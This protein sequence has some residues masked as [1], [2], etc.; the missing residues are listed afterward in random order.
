[1]KNFSLILFSFVLCLSAM[2]I[3]Q[4]EAV[5][6]KAKA[7]LAYEQGELDQAIIL[8]DSLTKEFRSL[9]LEYNL[10]NAYFRSKKIPL[11]ILHYERALRIAPTDV[12]VLHNLA[13]ARNLTVDRV[14]R[15]AGS[16]LTE[17]WV[18]KLLLVGESTWAWIGVLMAFLFAGF[19]ALFYWRKQSNIRQVFI[20]LAGLSLVLCILSSTFSFS[21]RNAMT[22]RDAAVIMTPKVD[23]VSAPNESATKLFVLHEGTIVNVVQEDAIWLNISLP[24]G[25]IGWVRKSEVEVI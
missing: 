15:G 12:D 4:D 25:L 3:S 9:E 14:E 8:Y 16:G 7:D 19:I 10:G 13:L 21:A 22:A 20:G 24:N 18:G 17:W 23:V 1:M 5:T 2:A 6:M 11:S